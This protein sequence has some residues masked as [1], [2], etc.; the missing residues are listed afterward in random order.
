LFFVFSRYRPKY[1]PIYN[2][3]MHIIVNI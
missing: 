1:S 2:N 3:Y